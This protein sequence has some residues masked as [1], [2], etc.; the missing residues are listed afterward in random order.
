MAKW[1]LDSVQI[2]KSRG[3][4]YIISASYDEINTE[5]YKTI[6]E[7]YIMSKLVFDIDVIEEIFDNPIIERE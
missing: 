7:D 6:T 4:E 3:H 5:S 1:R 2:S